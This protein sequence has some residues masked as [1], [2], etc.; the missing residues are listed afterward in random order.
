MLSTSI[1]HETKTHII[2]SHLHSDSINRPNKGGHRMFR[3]FCG[4]HV[5]GLLLYLD[6]K[7]STDIHICVLNKHY[8]MVK[9]TPES[10]FIPFID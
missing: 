6:F 3:I 4:L 7:L 2:I 9:L 10:V 8:S 1:K 5:F